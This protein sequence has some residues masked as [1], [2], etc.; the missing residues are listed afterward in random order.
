MLKNKVDRPLTKS[1][2]PEPKNQQSTD[3][4]IWAAWA[5]RITFE[6]IKKKQAKQNRK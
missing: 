2:N 3:W 6:E 4:I 1:S 5:D